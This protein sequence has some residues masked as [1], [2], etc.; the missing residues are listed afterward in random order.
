MDT[1]PWQRSLTKRAPYFAISVEIS[2]AVIIET[3]P[4]LLAVIINLTVK[5]L[6]NVDCVFLSIIHVFTII[7]IILKYSE[8]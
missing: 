8:L 7:I 1:Y 4:V 2:S 5:E 3:L 6:A